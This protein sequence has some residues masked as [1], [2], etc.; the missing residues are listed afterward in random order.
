M[1]TYDNVTLYVESEFGFGYRKIECRTLTVE[2]RKY[3]QYEA[4]VD[5][6]FVPKGKRKERQVIEA[7]KPSAVILS[8]FGHPEPPD[9]FTKAVTTTNADGTEVTTSQSRGLSNDPM[10]A[11]EFG[12]MLAEYLKD[13]KKLH[14]SGALPG[15]NGSYVLRDFRGHNSHD[16]SL[17]V[18]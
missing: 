6:C 15:P 17:R 3:A 5:L 1:K 14:F 18:A 4:A 13:T 16:A 10:Y 7:Y 12:K 2:I 11:N 8:G 9:A